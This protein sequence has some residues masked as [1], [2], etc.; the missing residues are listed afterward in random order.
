MTTELDC[1]IWKPDL[2]KMLG[3]GPQCIRVWVKAGKLPKPDVDLSMR[4]KGWRMSSLR[5]AGINL[6]YP[7]RESLQHDA[8]LRQVGGVVV[9]PSHGVV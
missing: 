4:T 9:G 6:V 7:V 2:V 3:V 8:A 5:A 1:V